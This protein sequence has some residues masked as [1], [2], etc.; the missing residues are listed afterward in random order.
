MEILHGAIAMLEA[1][2][3][4]ARP[5]GLLEEFKAKYLPELEAAAPA[6]RWGLKLPALP[7]MAWPQI[8]WPTVGRVLVP[9]GG[10][11]AAA[12]ALLL[13]WNS[14]PTI[15]GAA[16]TVPSV[17]IADVSA[18]PVSVAVPVPTPPSVSE[19]A[20]T[21]PAPTTDRT[22][23]P[24]VRVQPSFPKLRV[25]PKPPKRETPAPLVRARQ[26]PILAAAPTPPNLERRRSRGP[27]L[28]AGEQYASGMMGEA[29]LTV[30]ELA[31]I[32]DHVEAMPS[33]EDQ[34]KDISIVTHRKASA[35][36]VEEGYAEVSSRNLTTGEVK[37]AIIGAPTAAPPA[38]PSAGAAAPLPADAEADR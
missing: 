29:E 15:P 37:T 33:P 16:P 14:Q 21:R 32:A 35:A 24:A 25:E 31:R 22:A 2:K 7:A 6:P 18:P 12:A 38:E 26:R 27:R 17:R 36:P 13:A 8:E 1:P 19:K 3:S 4:M 20:V 5:E 9:M 28:K 10:M 23:S 34:W 30:E 11:A